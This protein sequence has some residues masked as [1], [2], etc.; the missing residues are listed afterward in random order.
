MAK[1]SYPRDQWQLRLMF[2]ML[3]ELLESPSF[4][5]KWLILFFFFSRTWGL[6]N[7][8]MTVSGYHRQLNP[9]N[10]ET[11]QPWCKGIQYRGNIETRGLRLPPDFVPKSHWE[12]T[13]TNLAL[14]IRFL[15]PGKCL[16]HCWRHPY[17]AFS[18]AA[19]Y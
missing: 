13:G 9:T 8:V 17:P 16:L 1:C 10:G 14:A 4:K 15:L 6:E 12:D 11:K 7:K 19:E 5:G 3:N 2:S 18:P